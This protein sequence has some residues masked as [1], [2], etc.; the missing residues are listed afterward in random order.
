MTKRIAALFVTAMFLC[1]AVTSL[2]LAEGGLA[3]FA[4]SSHD[5]P[6]H[7]VGVALDANVLATFDEDVNAGTVTSATFVLYGHLGGLASGTFG[8]DGGT[9]TVTLAP[10]RAFHTGE[11][12]RVSATEGISSTGA[13]ALTPYGWQFTAGPVVD[14]RVA[15]FIDTGAVLSDVYAS[16]AD[17]G[18]YDGD[19]DLDILLMGYTGSTRVSTVYRNDGPAGFTD[20]GAGFTAVSYGDADWGD[21]DNDGDLDALLTGWTD[22]GKGAQI[23][24]NDGTSGFYDIDAGLTTV[25]NGSVAWGDYD[26][27]G[28]LDILLTGD[29]HIGAVSIVYRNDGVSGFTDIGAALTGV[30]YSAAEWGDYD[31]D[32]DLDIVLSGLSSGGTVSKVYRNDGGGS[33]AE[34][35]AGLLAVEGSCAA[36]GD[37]DNDGDLDI[38]LGGWT[39]EDCV[40]RLYRND[41][42]GAFTDTIAGL[43]DMCSA[44]VAWGDVDNDGDLDILQTGHGADGRA[45]TVYRNDWGTAFVDIGAGL[46]G[47]S[48]GSA[49]WGDVEGD[50]DLDILLTGTPTSHP[51]FT[52]LSMIYRNNSTPKLGTVTPSS[53]SGP[54]G[55]TRYFTTTWT[56]PDGWEDLKH[57]YFHIGDT[58]SIVGNVTLLYNAAKDKLWLRSDDGSAWTGGHAPETATT[59]ENSQAIVHCNL[60]TAQGSEDTLS[61]AW[62]IE[63]KPGYTGAKKLGLKC[64]DRDKTK[65]KGKWKGA[66][67][68]G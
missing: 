17:W 2:L 27:D 38:L 37:Y 53:G 23:Y 4:I 24:R 7:E 36:W 45:S 32:G 56:D 58:P 22:T 20:I 1:I 49:A 6:T 3:P 39:G 47:L 5:P 10:G 40:S 46:T 33:F 54:T 66:W 30:A 15:G 13:A 65:A 11:V 26:N 48:L 16:D 62:A 19:G 57:C 29:A 35:S 28:D 44:S 63:F 12:L 52:G 67:T 64:K 25:A 18:D 42:G 34:I 9:R 43:P 31:N 50:G 14:R 61:V 68:I 21:Y 59:L 41:G 55:V 60:T 8:Y 51:S